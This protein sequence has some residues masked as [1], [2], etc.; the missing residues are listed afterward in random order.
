MWDR[1]SWKPK[2]CPDGG[3]LVSVAVWQSGVGRVRPARHPLVSVTSGGERRPRR[4]GGLAYGGDPPT[5]GIL[6]QS[7]VSKLYT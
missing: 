6:Q 5:L 1:G 2:R 3:W 4:H 7:L